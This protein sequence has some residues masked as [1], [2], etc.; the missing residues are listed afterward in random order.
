MMPLSLAVVFWALIGLSFVI[1][2]ILFVPALKKRNLFRV[3]MILMIILSLL[4]GALIFLTLKQNVGGTFKIFLILAGTAPAAMVLSSIL[5]NVICALAEAFFGKEF[6]EA[7]FFITAV[8]V[9]PAI[10]LVGAIGS[11]VLIIKGG[12]QG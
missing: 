2:C 11:I 5:H 3:L 10:F 6:E 4:G 9:C 12:V 8:F 1:T 7:V